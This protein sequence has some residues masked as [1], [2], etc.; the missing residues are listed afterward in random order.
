[1]GNPETPSKSPG[2]PTLRT[3]DLDQSKSSLRPAHFSFFDIPYCIFN[4]VFGVHGQIKKN[5]GRKHECLYS[6]FEH[7]VMVHFSLLSPNEH[8]NNKHKMILTF[9]KFFLF[10]ILGSDITNYAGQVVWPVNSQPVASD[11][12]LE[13]GGP[14]YSL[15]KLCW[16][17]LI[18]QGQRLPHVSK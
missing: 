14:I 4:I 9:F 1:M 18:M 16:P 2:G 17:L 3:N 12:P 6:Y 7:G 15:R 11:W 13:P 5:P 10:F 8:C